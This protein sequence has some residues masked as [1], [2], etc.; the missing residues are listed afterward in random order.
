MRAEG[1]MPIIGSKFDQLTGLYNREAFYREAT[2]LLGAR[3]DVKYCIVSICLDG[4][5]INVSGTYSVIE[6]F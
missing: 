5:Y 1:I 3:Y 4:E 6:T 2:L